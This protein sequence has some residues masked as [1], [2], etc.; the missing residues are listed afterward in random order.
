MR[1]TLLAIAFASS[2]FS[3]PVA[4]AVMQSGAATDGGSLINLRT[5]KALEH[6][7]EF[8]A[9]TWTITAAGIADGGKY[10]GYTVW[11]SVSGCIADLNCK[12]GYRWGYNLLD[13]DGLLVSG[14][15]TSKSPIGNTKNAAL[16][17]AAAKDAGPFTFSLD[18]A[19]TLYFTF[20]DSNYADNRG[21]VSLN[22]ALVQTPSND[23]PVPAT[24]LLI[25]LGLIGLTR[26]AA[27]R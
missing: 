17:L 7:V 3:A 12:Q 11:S 15:N 9:G 24:A 18:T 1:K 10:D 23:V 22:L 4:A 5:D 19:Q 20:T 2:V 27:N 21:G 13:A 26:R 25:G 8:T 6:A 14:F 16:A